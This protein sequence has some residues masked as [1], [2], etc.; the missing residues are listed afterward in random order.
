MLVR[1]R[2]RICMT[3]PSKGK[4]NTETHNQIIND[5][6]AHSF[7]T[8]PSEPDPVLVKLKFVLCQQLEHGWVNCSEVNTWRAM[9]M[10]MGTKQIQTQ[11]RRAGKIWMR[12]NTM[13]AP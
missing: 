4:P 6:Y 1:Q 7:R 12:H 13:G 9:K 5:V 11:N 8:A 10:R 3:M 2:E